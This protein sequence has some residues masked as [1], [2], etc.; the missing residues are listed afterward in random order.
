MYEKRQKVSFYNIASEASYFLFSNFVAK[1]NI[2]FIDKDKD[3]LTP[4]IFACGYG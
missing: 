2:D 4:F 1:I 3:G